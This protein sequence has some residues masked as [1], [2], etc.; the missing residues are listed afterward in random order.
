MN[1]EEKEDYDTGDIDEPVDIVG[2]MQKDYNIRVLQEIRELL[3]LSEEKY[4]HLPNKIKE[5]FK[6]VL[7]EN[8]DLLSQNR[9]DTSIRL[10]R[11]QKNYKIN[12]YNR[13][14]IVRE[15]KIKK[16]LQKKLELTNERWKKLPDIVIKVLIFIEIKKQNRHKKFWNLQCNLK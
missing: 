6:E 4:D 10:L 2:R 14:L 1:E 3:G 15:Q 9:Y 11:D 13:F 16:D 8:K 12:R 5:V 7:S